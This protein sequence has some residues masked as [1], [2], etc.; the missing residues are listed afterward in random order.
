MY[1]VSVSQQ[2]LSVY[3]D[4]LIVIVNTTTPKPI[5]VS[6]CDTNQNQFQASTV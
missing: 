6:M 5:L 1:L 4:Y 3:L 2:N